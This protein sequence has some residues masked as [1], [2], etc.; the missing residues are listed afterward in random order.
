[1]R[2]DS[3]QSASLTRG[4]PTVFRCYIRMACS[5]QTNRYRVHLEAAWGKHS[6]TRFDWHVLTYLNEP[7]WKN[8]TASFPHSKRKW[9]ERACCTFSSVFLTYLITILFLSPFYLP[10]CPSTPP[11][12]SP[13]FLLFFVFPSSGSVPTVPPGNVQAEPVNSTTVRFTWSAPS[14]QFIN[15]INQGYKVNSPPSVNW[16]SLVVRGRRALC[17]QKLSRLLLTLWEIVSII[18]KSKN[19]W[20]QNKILKN[21]YKY[22]HHEF[23]H[24][25]LYKL[26]PC[27]HHMM[28]S[29]AGMGTRSHKWGHR[30]YGASKLP[31]QCSCRLHLQP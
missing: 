5:L 22:N 11:L 30:G 20:F 19:K 24:N 16:C 31:G 25:V 7:E 12:I 4:S 9:S 6:H 15:G 10:A 8:A 26:K 28:F 21:R 14:P 1:M 23:L 27:A 17:H 3:C 18:C 2:T 29:A 13:S